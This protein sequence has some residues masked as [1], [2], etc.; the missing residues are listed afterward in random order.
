MGPQERRTALHLSDAIPTHFFDAYNLPDNST[1]ILCA[2]NTHCQAG[3]SRASRPPAGRGLLPPFRGHPARGPGRQCRPMAPRPA[4]CGRRPCGPDAAPARPVRRGRRD[5]PP[6]RQGL[7]PPVRGWGNARSQTNVKPIIGHR[8]EDV[9]R[10]LRLSRRGA[11][12]PGRAR[13]PVGLSLHRRPA[14]DRV[15]FTRSAWCLA[16]SGRRH[17]AG[18]QR[19]AS[20][21]QSWPSRCSPATW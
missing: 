20:L 2:C 1:H 19:P 18:R 7:L 5:G 3:S 11:R 13:M 12:P 15:D 10:A 16:A 21:G 9:P 4:R 6:D 17:G 8:P 14:L